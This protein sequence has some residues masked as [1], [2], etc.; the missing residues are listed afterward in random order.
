MFVKSADY[1]ADG[2]AVKL[3]STGQNG[4]AA[5]F[6]RLTKDHLKP[7]QAAIEHRMEREATF[8]VGTANRRNV[9]N[10]IRPEPTS[11]MTCPGCG[12]CFQP[13]VYRRFPQIEGHPICP[14]CEEPLHSHYATF[15]PDLP[16]LCIQAS[17]SEAGCCPRCGSQVA[18][19]VERAE[20]AHTGATTTNYPE[21]MAANRMALLRQAAREKGQEYASATQTLSWRPTCACPEAA[22]PVPATVLDPYAGT[23]T[24]LLAAMRL[25]RR[26]VGVDL[27]EDYLKM[28]VQRL[29]GQTL[30]LGAL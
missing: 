25:G 14:R 28:A 23:G 16:R 18:R 19:V 21:G 10:D 2:E 5:N 13:K 20:A 7:S 12:R 11:D 29:S 24:T 9:W 27:S 8:D 3:I 4:M 17:T 30:P 6:Q 1:W 26:S 15:P 22:S